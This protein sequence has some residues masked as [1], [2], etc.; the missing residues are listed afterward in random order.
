MSLLEKQC[1]KSL[2]NH[3]CV[4]FQLLG[5]SDHFRTVAGSEFSFALYLEEG[6]KRCAVGGGQRVEK[7]PETREGSVRLSLRT[8]GKN[9]KESKKEPCSPAAPCPAP[10]PPPQAPPPRS[11]GF[12]APWDHLFCVYV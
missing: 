12:C 1:W 3:V 5:I 9:S 7:S 10:R 8:K 4:S 6:C 11:C 2:S